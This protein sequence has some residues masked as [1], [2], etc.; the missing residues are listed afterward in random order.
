M[1]SLTNTKI[2]DTYPLLLKIETNGV[3]G[4]LRSIEDGDGTTS[5][6]KISSGAIQVDNI[7]IDGNAITS[8]D[9]NGNIDLTPN[10]SGEVNISKVDIDSGAIDGTPIGANSANTGAFTTISASGNVDFNGDLDVDGTTNLDVVDID[11][12]VD[13]ASTLTVG[14]DVNVTA[15]GA[16]FF[17]SSA[18]Y[19]LVSI[20]RAGSS[21]SALDQGYLRMKSAG[22]N[23]IA[24]HTAG[25]SY[26][27]GGSLGLGTTSPNAKLDISGDTSTWA[28]MAK[29][30]LTDVNSNS[31]SRNWSIGN[32]GTAYG[33]LSFIVSNAE[34]GVPADSTGTAVMSMDGV[35]KLVGIGTASPSSYNSNT[36]NLV[37]RDS[38]SG[39][40]TISTG[41]SNTGYLAFN[42]GEDTTIEGLIAYNQSNDT[43]SFRTAGTDNRLVINGSGKVGIGTNDPSDQ[44]T[45]SNSGEASVAIIGS[46]GVGGGDATLYLVENTTDYGIRMRYDGGDDRFYI[47]A[48]EDTRNLMTIER[49]GSGVG[50]HTT[51]PNVGGYTSERGVLT[52]GSTDN[53]S[54]NN[55]A[56]LELQGHAISN[57]VTVGDISFF[58][59]T[60]QNAIVRGG[61]DSSTTTG[62]LSFFTNGGSGVGERMRITS[63][64][65][66]GI[67]TDNPGYQLDL[68]RNDT[69]TA[70]SLGI[71]QLG[72]GDASMAFQTT[73]S[74]YGF[75]I[76]VDGSDSDAFKIATGTDDIGTNTKLTITSGGNVGIGTTSPSENVH[77][78]SSASAATTLRI[79]ATAS[80][81]RADIALYGNYT[82]SNNEFSEILFVNNTDSVCAIQAGRDTNDGNGSIKFVTQ[83]AT[84][85]QGMTI[86]AIV[87]SEGDFFTNDGTVSSL[88]DKR[89]KKDIADLEDGLS[90]I[91]QLKPKTFKYNGKTA[92]GSED[93]KTRYGFIA[94]DV[95]EVASQ[96]VEIGTEKIDGVEVD[97]FKS[98][99]MMRMFPM[100]VKAVQELSAKVEALENA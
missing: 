25:D 70:T 83:A 81:Q 69:G 13:M 19:E 34:D 92:L 31:S 66:V 8:T 63:G 17:V 3:D 33:A 84:L 26:F 71:R 90:I 9:S 85:S 77:I 68:R 57:D 75:C 74:P 42:D 100:L 10:G 88:S 37:I 45:I 73:T 62:F 96:Y 27:N 41:A 76:G 79:E 5:A 87:S 1:A 95:L 4:T 30:Y 50:I 65:N 94:D 91:N 16:R 49:D 53:G 60:N 46:A 44:L 20:G 56:N 22:T 97:D 29:I 21:G 54:A 35:N 28:G 51:S 80:S 23:T 55:Y 99:S 6:L 39:G 11:G 52:I 93:N 98:L 48:D 32:G 82:G 67:G 72:T 36:N 64:G 18:D 58:D 47:N 61:R 7:K 40:I 89:T 38:G 24:L 78:S 12:A 2:S 59:H 43:M 15:D 14:G 86:R